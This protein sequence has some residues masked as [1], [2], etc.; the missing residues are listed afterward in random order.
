[1]GVV[2]NDDLSGLVIW[3]G[4]L[5]VFMITIPCLFSVYY[6]FPGFTLVGIGE[7]DTSTANGYVALM[8]SLCALLIPIQI[9]TTIQSFVQSL[10][11]C[12]SDD[13]QALDDTHPAES[14]ML[15]NAA[16]GHKQYQVKYD[17]KYIIVQQ[18]QQGYI[19]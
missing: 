14:Q 16:Y 1:M 12:W 13:P 15:K 5:I 17:D 7:F 6:F 8:F 10:Y 9:L 3:M 18:G 2:I 19:A 11:V 4:C